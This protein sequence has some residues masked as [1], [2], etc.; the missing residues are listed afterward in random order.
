MAS[1]QGKL[2]ERVETARGRLGDGVEEL[3]AKT[4]VKNRARKSATDIRRIVDDKTP[5][6][7]RHAAGRAGHVVE[8]SARAG[9]KRPV[10]TASLVG[11]TVLA[12]VL[13]LLRRSRGNSH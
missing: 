11:G 9:K 4:G 5:D 12:L 2:R 1:M 6:R 10:P 3:A 7:M 13:L 8:R